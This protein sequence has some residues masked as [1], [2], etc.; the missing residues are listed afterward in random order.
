M[1]DLS[2]SAFRQSDLD[3]RTFPAALEDLFFLSEAEWEAA[4]QNADF[5]FVVIGS[6]YCAYAFVE[7]TLLRQPNARILL[8][9]R[10][11]FY[12]TDH[13]YNMTVPCQEKFTNSLRSFETY[14]WDLSAHTRKGDYISWLHGN[15]SF[16]G[17]RSTM[18][19]GWSPKPTP[20]DMTGWPGKTI[21]RVQWNFKHANDLL[22]VSAT[23]EIERD[24]QGY[25]I[26]THPMY[27]VM[28]DRFIDILKKSV[29]DI[30]TIE[31]VEP[32]RF[33]TA[34][35]HSHKRHST[36]SKLLELINKQE[37][38]AS[39]GKGAPLSI[40]V[41]CTVDR[42][43]HQ[44]NKATM[45][46]TSRGIVQM[47]GAQLVLATGTMEATK[48]VANS[49]P[50]EAHPALKHVGNRFTAHFA[51]NIV[52]RF[53]RD[54][55][56][57]SEYVREWELGAL[58]LPASVAQ[59]GGSYHVQ[60]LV[61]SDRDPKKNAKKTFR[62]VPELGLKTSKRQLES[63]EEHVVVVGTPMGAM[64]H[65]NTDNWF[66]K[67]SNG[68]HTLPFLANEND[69]CV[70]DIMDNATYQIIEKLV[71]SQS[72]GA[73]GQVEYWVGG[74]EDGN[75]SS[76][77][78]LPDQIRRTAVMHEGS[79]LWLGDEDDQEAPVDTDYKLRGINNV[80]VTGGGLWPTGGSWN[81]TVTMVA[82][83]QDLADHLNGCR[84]QPVRGL[85]A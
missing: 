28:Q 19:L 10:G 20:R 21:E 55:F 29:S 38:L 1:Y 23:D 41:N 34:E 42:I 52:A 40:V 15:G 30:P 60:L 51:S 22:N 43:I 32:A 7:R 24:A 50:S 79:T 74:P 25:P 44:Q 45:L 31:R 83:A 36:P 54:L 6:S 61:L 11:S 67:S 70:W 84:G 77:R 80:Y 46:D 12:L 85:A 8:I 63:S 49:F 75:W 71:G 35:S 73:A 37:A 33:S 59:T 9:E 57:F 53:P 62:Y 16:L 72:N 82:L 48:L 39:S 26:G 3:H 65:R 56:D 69:L 18:W 17:G 78:P 14:S 68:D 58:Y 13:L 5:D 47:G 66:R 76:S 4:G 27:G 2:K 81:P 64:D